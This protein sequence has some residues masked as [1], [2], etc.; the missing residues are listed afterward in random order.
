M[1]EGN[2]L[3]NLVPEIHVRF[4]TK[5]QNVYIVDHDL[6]FDYI[7]YSIDVSF[8]II[9][10]KILYQSIDMLKLI[11]FYLIYLAFFIYIIQ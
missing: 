1:I 8:E 2:F 7:V 11:Y 4:N 5:Y 10:C 9:G 3:Y 6:L